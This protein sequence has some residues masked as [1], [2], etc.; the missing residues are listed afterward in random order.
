MD[1]S[2]PKAG[3]KS[4]SVIA[5]KLQM[6][7]DVLRFATSNGHILAPMTRLIE[8]SQA[9]VSDV[10]YELGRLTVEA[11]LEISAE[12]AAGPRHQGKRADSEIVRHGRQ[13]GSV[14]LADR[15]IAVDRPRL[16]RRGG[17]DGAE[18]EVPAYAAMQNGTAL[19][20]H[21]LNAMMHGVSTRN[22]SQVLSTA[23]QATGVSKSSV[24]RHFVAATEREYAAL[25]ARRFDDVAVV[26]IYIDGIILGD[27]HVI[28]AVG[29]DSTGKKHILGLMAGATENARV[30]K[31]LLTD[32]VERGIKPGFK[33]LFVIDGS[34]A[35]RSAIAAVFGQDAAV[36]RCRVHKVRNVTDYLPE[37]RKAEAKRAMHA[38]FQMEPDAGKRKLLRLAETFEKEY[39]GAAGSLREGLDEMFTVN[40]LGVAG[41]LASR[42]VNTNI[43]ESANSGARRRTNRIGDWKTGAMALRWSAAAFLANEARFRRVIGYNDID[44]LITALGNESLEKAA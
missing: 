28:A 2:Y 30:V 31:D 18:V 21:V 37:D 14:T 12:D 22:Y 34:K 36:Q 1:R 43:I 5:T 4:K 33:R 29:I 8:Q 17:G 44:S 7:N 11:V 25:V 10:I 38:A 13:P 9:L 26:I 41:S 42:L 27:H 35:L 16:R 39:P 15:R 32:I 24:S 20:G 40:C 23:A 6:Q 19:Q 3:G